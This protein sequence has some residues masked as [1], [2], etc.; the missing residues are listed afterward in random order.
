MLSRKLSRTISFHHMPKNASPRTLVCHVYTPRPLTQDT[1]LHPAEASCQMTLL[2]DSVHPREMV[3]LLQ[4]SHSHHPL[5][6]QGDVFV[7][8]VCYLGPAGRRCVWRFATRTFGTACVRCRTL[9]SNR[10]YSSVLGFGTKM[11]TPRYFRTPCS[12]YR[13][14]FA[15]SFGLTSEN[16][17]R[18]STA[19]GFNNLVFE[20]MP[21][22]R[23]MRNSNVQHLM[24]RGSLLHDTQTISETRLRSKV[25]KVLILLEFRRASF[26]CESL[27]SQ[28]IEE[29]LQ[30]NEMGKNRWTP[31]I[32]PLT[33]SDTEVS[34]QKRSQRPLPPAST[35]P[36]F[37]LTSCAPLHM[38][39]PMPRAHACTTSYLHLRVEGGQ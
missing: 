27:V 31:R 9:Q 17:R 6:V 38:V 21:P 28:I 13:S 8:S 36:P 22:V 16:L 10:I 29:P 24:R 4:P 37:R 14:Y 25:Y 39:H 32:T 23:R 15:K 33:S 3:D 19:C 35:P 34:V 30:G 26:S 5:L 7:A 12:G 20:T 2:A 18:Y 11:Y 1:C